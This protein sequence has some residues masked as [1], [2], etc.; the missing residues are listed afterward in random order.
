MILICRGP[1]K[2]SIDHLL[3]RRFRHRLSAEGQS[4]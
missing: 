3:W 1:G 2:L 4:A